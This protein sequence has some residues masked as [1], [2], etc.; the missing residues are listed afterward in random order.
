MTSATDDAERTGLKTGHYKAQSDTPC[1]PPKALGAACTKARGQYLYSSSDVLEDCLIIRRVGTIGIVN[2]PVLDLVPLAAGE[3]SFF[4][5]AA[6]IDDQIGGRPFIVSNWFGVQNA[7]R[8][9]VFAERFQ[10]EFLHH[11]KR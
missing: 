7:G 6:H 11:A 8:I 3:S 9:T 1:R 4:E 2:I 10:S 5:V